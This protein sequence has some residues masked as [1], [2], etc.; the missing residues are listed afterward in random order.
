MNMVLL[1]QNRQLIACQTN[2][3]QTSIAGTFE[4]TSSGI[5]RF[6][7]FLEQHRHTQFVVV[8]DLEAEQLHLQQIPRMSGRDQNSILRHHQRKLFGE[9][10]YTSAIV[11]N[12]KTHAESRLGVSLIGLPADYNECVWLTELSD[13]NPIVR[14]FHW[15][16]LLIYPLAEAAGMASTLTVFI[17]RMSA[18]DDRIMGFVGRQPLICRRLGEQSGTISQ[19]DE[20]GA[21]LADQLQQTFAYLERETEIVGLQAFDEKSV[22]VVSVGDLTAEEKQAID[23]QLD[24][25]GISPVQSMPASSLTKGASA[26]SVTVAVV[27]ATS[28]LSGKSYSYS[29]ISRGVRYLERRLR[30]AM[31]ACSISLIFS[32][33]MASAAVRYVEA[34]LGQLELMA[35]QVEVQALTLR[36]AHAHPEWSDQYAI[37]AIREAV[38]HVNAIE[39]ANQS[40]PFHFLA[41][42]SEHLT[43]HP[44]IELKSIQWADIDSEKHTDVRE[45]S[46]RPLST[47]ESGRRY[48]AV[49]SGSV[50]L[51]SEGYRPAVSQFRSFV[52][53][54]RE[55]AMEA[56]PGAVVT[57]VNLPF[58]EAGSVASVTGASQGGFIL[59]VSS[60]WSLQ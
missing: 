38:V 43:R 30:H 45:D 53:S 23:Q 13:A 40:T 16:S 56:S 5:E 41:S 47:T 17:I 33:A 32:A 59:E 44:A 58:G 11:G 22:S 19:T 52:A 57:I 14:S 39:V 25:L 54:V 20:C 9:S 6:R 1:L 12:R 7:K 21:L 18:G 35:D 2:H 26:E 50:K 28:V 15:M 37:E 27:M 49:L 36:Q 10:L 4:D 48:H 46:D 55:S 8:L 24:V 34:D 60:S 3:G 29:L 51:T 31:V 42:L